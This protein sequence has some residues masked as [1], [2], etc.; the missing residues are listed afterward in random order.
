MNNPK[1]SVIIPAY[2]IAGYIKKCL[3]SV[4]TQSF[5][6]FEIIII[7][8]GSADATGDIADGYAA[9]EKRVAVVHKKNGGVSAARNDGIELASGDYFLFYDG[10]DFI[11]PYALEEL[12]RLIREKEADVLV[13]GY[14]RYRDGVLTEVCRPVFPEGTYAGREIIQN[15]LSRFVGFSFD[16]VN[17]WLKG[18]RGGL[19]VENPALWRCMVR[20]D[21]IR[22]DRVRFDVNLKIGEDTVF[23]SDLLSCVKNCYVSHKCYY[24]LVYRESSAIAAYETNAVAKLEGK[25]RLMTARNALTDRVKERSGL[26][27]K[28]YWQGTVI[29]SVIELA[30]L[31]ANKKGGA[32]FKNR[33]RS[34]LSYAKRDEVTE[35]ARAFEP[36]VKTSVKSLPFFMLKK[37]WHFPLFICAAIL[38][39]I[40]YKFVR[41]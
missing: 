29:M 5:N 12:Y 34:Y 17:R 37:G 32:S 20:A 24:Y 26:D 40:N 7:D 19:Y 23:M 6:D 4:L 41:D 8:D 10:D 39:L 1:I 9:R 16:G 36:R 21:V 22:N 18:E 15:L 30:F 28:P 11:E 14:N 35:A 13:Y 3:D 27:I 2:N 31:F 38:N 33:Y 25:R